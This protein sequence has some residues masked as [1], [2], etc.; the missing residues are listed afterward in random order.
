MV[1]EGRS[2]LEGHL[3]LEEPGRLLG[4][5]QESRQEVTRMEAEAGQHQ[6]VATLEDLQA[7]RQAAILAEVDRHQLEANPAARRRLVWA[8]TATE[9]PGAKPVWVPVLGRALGRT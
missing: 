1:A 2:A 3:V 4:A 8:A 7:F 6:P 9:A 5:L